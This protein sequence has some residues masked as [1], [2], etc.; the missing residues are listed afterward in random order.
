MRRVKI[1]VL[2]DPCKAADEDS[3]VEGVELE[4]KLPDVPGKP[5]VLAFCDEHRKELYDPL[6]AVLIDL[7][8]PISTPSRSRGGPPERDEDGSIKANDVQSPCYVCGQLVKRKSWGSHFLFVHPEHDLAMMRFERGDATDLL[9]CS[10]GKS[11]NSRS[12]YAIHQKRSEQPGP[13]EIVE[14]KHA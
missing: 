2:C 8:Q 5:R 12:G 14:E 1:D 3:E 7:G 6:V 11:F 4:I 9:T 13:H 10:C